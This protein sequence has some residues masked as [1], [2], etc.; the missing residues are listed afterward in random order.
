[1]SKI[2]QAAKGEP[3]LMRLSICNHDPAT[4]VLAH[5]RAAGNAGTGIKPPDISGVFACSACHDAIDGRTRYPVEPVEL[6]H[7]ILRT[8]DRLRSMGLVK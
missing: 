5:V 1:M 8:H 7:G 2:R 4:T 6:L 3:C